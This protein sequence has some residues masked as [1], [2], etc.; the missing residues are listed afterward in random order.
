MSHFEQVNVIGM[1]T[2]INTYWKSNLSHFM[3]VYPISNS[4][5]LPGHIE[6]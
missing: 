5:Q 1:K 3:R 6:L 2:L 4:V